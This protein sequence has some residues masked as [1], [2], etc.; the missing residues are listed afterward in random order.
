M[1]EENYGRKRGRRTYSERKRE[2]RKRQSK[3]LEACFI[4]SLNSPCLKRSPDDPLSQN[5]ND[6]RHGQRDFNTCLTCGGH[7][8]STV[9]TIDIAVN[10]SDKQILLCATFEEMCAD[11]WQ[12][13][14]RRYGL[15]SNFSQNLCNKYELYGSDYSSNYSSDYA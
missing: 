10:V 2:Q 1:Q 3:T 7:Q 4:R 9:P 12:Y 15:N 11:V 8:S 14:P 13:L 5:I 6:E